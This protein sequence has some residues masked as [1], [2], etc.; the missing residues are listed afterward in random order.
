M[1]MR[2]FLLLM[3]TD[4]ARAEP[5]SGWDAYL[6]KLNESGCFRGGSAIGLGKCFRKQGAPGALAAHLSGFVRVAA[7]DLDAARAFLDGNPTF[8]AGGTVEI[9]ELPLT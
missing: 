6:Q 1:A 9:R 7:K 4:T 5:D 3:H 8:E 2:E